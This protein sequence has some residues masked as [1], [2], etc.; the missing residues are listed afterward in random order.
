MKRMLALLAMIMA[1]TA[2]GCASAPGGEP[3][4]YAEPLAVG[5]EYDDSIDADNTNP[6]TFDALTLTIHDSEEMS[7][8]VTWNTLGRAK[9]QVVQV[10]EGGSFDNCTEFD[11]AVR[12][13][14]KKFYL[15]DSEQ[16]Y[17]Y[18]S[19]A[20]IRG[21]EL[22]KTYSY[23]CYDKNAG[24]YSDVFTFT[25]RNGKEKSFRFAYVSDSQTAGE[26]LS[27]G[28]YY[29]DTLKGI[30]GHGTPDFILHGGDVAEYSSCESYWHNMLNSNKNAF[31]T[32]PVMPT[33]GNHEASYQSA[34]YTISN[35][36]NLRHPEQNTYTG[37]YYSFD[38]GNAK[39]IV[40]DTNSVSAKGLF[41]EQYSWLENELKTNKQ[42]WT[43]VSMH[44]PMYSVGKWGAE[45]SGRLLRAQ[46]K[47]LFAEYEVDL[48]LQGHDHT[49]S[50]TYPINAEGKANTS[51]TYKN[52]DGIDYCK[53]PKGTI[54]VVSGPAGNQARNYVEE[55][56]TGEFEK[57]GNAE[58][59]SWAEIEVTDKLLTVRRWY[60][61]NG[62]PAVWESY[63]IRK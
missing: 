38:Y 20:V 37:V 29:A 16:S 22:G 2:C 17:L 30:S 53:K 54:Y 21:L 39:F 25:A 60:Y 4:N 63:G 46:L 52:I 31:A 11:V 34:P 35:H 13:E 62:E 57:Y 59:S 7:Y 55:N 18:I 8:G 33:S 56:V 27:S 5:W 47:S 28:E 41:D 36:F 50:K 19:K 12:R 43:I 58:P 15:D 1:M 3:V 48:V 61:N 26:D 42:K 40:L 24:V 9:E 49:Y 45:V 23:R 44:A 6:I 10:S 32:I 14:E 51:V